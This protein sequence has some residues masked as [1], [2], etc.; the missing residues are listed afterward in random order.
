MPGGP[1]RDRNAGLWVAVNGESFGLRLGDAPLQPVQNT[2]LPSRS[3][4]PDPGKSTS[5]RLA[6]ALLA[7]LFAVAPRARTEPT[8]EER[9]HRLFVVWGAGIVNG[10]FV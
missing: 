8:R 5:S 7:M 3:L 9:E 1:S 6:R 4:L 10:A 2:G